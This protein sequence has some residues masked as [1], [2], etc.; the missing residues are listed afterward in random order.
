MSW[1]RTVKHLLGLDTD[2]PFVPN[3]RRD[4]GRRWLALLGRVLTCD[5]DRCCTAVLL[6]SALYNRRSDLQRE[7]RYQVRSI[8]LGPS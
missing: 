3:Y 7:P 5:H 6:Y 8:K 4:H 1:D 2:D